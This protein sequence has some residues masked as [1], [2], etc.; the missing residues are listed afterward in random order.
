LVWA[1][2]NAHRD[3]F[4]DIMFTDESFVFVVD[5]DHGAIFITRRPDERFEEDCLIPTFKQSKIRCMVWGCIIE[6]RKGPLV[7]LDYP[8]GRG[9][10]MTAVRYIEQVLEG[11]WGSFYEEVRKE[12]GGVIFL[13][14]D[15]ASP[16][17]IKVTQAWL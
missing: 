8:G 3:H 13:Q 12:R 2:S 6:G 15:G 5:G 11:A 14:Q 16:H 7:I 17:R 9:G 10:G 1:Q 4:D